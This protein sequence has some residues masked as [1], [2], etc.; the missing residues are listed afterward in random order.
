VLDDCK[1]RAE[2]APNKQWRKA[3]SGSKYEELMKPTFD[4][5]SSE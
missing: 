3:T 4:V 5:G 2:R 1:V